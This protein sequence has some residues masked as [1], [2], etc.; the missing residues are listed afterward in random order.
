MYFDMNWPRSPRTCTLT[1][2]VV[3]DHTTTTLTHTHT[4]SDA[5]NGAAFEKQIH[6]HS[7]TMQCVMIQNLYI[8][9]KGPM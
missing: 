8:N 9:K 4:H 3:V 2:H 1:Y 7:E 5:H 6:E